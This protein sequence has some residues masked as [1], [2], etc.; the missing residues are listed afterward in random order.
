MTKRNFDLCHFFQVYFV[1][2]SFIY[3][4]ANFNKILQNILM[5]VCVVIRKTC[6]HK[7]SPRLQ[8]HVNVIQKIFSH[9]FYTQ[10][11][12]ITYVLE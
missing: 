8:S 12:I 1:F 5:R 6:S 11:A 7:F 10:K 4:L 3:D 2:V 9:T